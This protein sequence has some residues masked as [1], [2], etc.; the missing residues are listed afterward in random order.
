MANQQGTLLGEWGR[1]DATLSDATSRKSYGQ[2][3]VEIIAGIRAGNSTAEGY[4]SCGLH[5]SRSAL[6]GFSEFPSHL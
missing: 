2:T 3:Q 4:H 1:K 6:S 5:L